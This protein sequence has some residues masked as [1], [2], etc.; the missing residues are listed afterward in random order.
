[1][2]VNWEETSWRTLEKWR[3]EAS[4]WACPVANEHHG[5]LPPSPEAKIEVFEMFCHKNCGLYAE[6]FDV[7]ECCPF[8]QQMAEEAPELQQI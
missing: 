5:E 7:W 3:E 2:L 4:E 8:G 1:M 6:P